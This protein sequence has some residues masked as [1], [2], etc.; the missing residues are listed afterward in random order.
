[1]TSVEQKSQFSDRRRR[2]WAPKLK[3]GCMTCKVR[4]VKCDEE[5]PHCR[6]CISTGRKCDG[7]AHP[8]FAVEVLKSCHNDD[9]CRQRLVKCDIIG[10]GSSSHLFESHPLDEVT[11]PYTHLSERTD[12]FPILSGRN[13]PLTYP[14]A[15]SWN[16]HF[17]PFVISNFR[18]SFKM[19]KSIY[20]TFPDVLSKAEEKSA[21]YQACNAVAYAYVANITRT[22][23][24]TSDRAK[25]YGFALMALRSAVQDSQLYKNDNTL[26]AIWLLGLY[27]LLLGAQNGTDPVTTPGWHIHNQVLSELIR[28]RGSEQFTTRKGRNLFIIIFNNVATQALMSGQECKEASTWFLLFHKYCEPSEYAMLRACIFSHHSASICSRARALVDTGDLD[29]VLSSS[30]AILQD[31]DEV[32]QATD[33]LSHEA[34]AS[35]VVDPPMAPYARPK[36][37]YPCYV[38]VQVLQSNFRMRLSYAVLEFLGYACKAPGCTPQ[39]RMIFKRYQRRC[40]EEIEALVDKVSRILDVLPDEGSDELLDQ[41]KGVVAELDDKDSHT[42]GSPDTE[43]APFKEPHDRSTPA[44]RA[45]LDFQQPI[46][47]KSTLLFKHSDCGVSVLRFGFGETNKLEAG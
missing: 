8:P 21:L 35:Y 6:R 46:D 28:L 15:E 7:Y 45:Y 32:E 47:G 30:P 39:Q 20:N 24:A 5:K 26:L 18:L 10:P 23:K 12:G 14:L 31:M 16:T 34:V 29:E 27:E 37:A 1:M 13:F 3:S 38:G 41:S 9:S 25:A 4:R 17:M 43:Q 19:A 36:Y 42:G 33:P 11:I 22:S 2:K 40:V 44:V